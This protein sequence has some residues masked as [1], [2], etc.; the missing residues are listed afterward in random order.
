V[1]FA[2][3][4]LARHHDRSRFDCGAE[5]LD[6]YIHHQAS[7]DMRRRMARVFVAVPEAST[8]VAGFYTLGAASL[9]RATLPPEDA[10]RLPHYP[11]PVVL[12]G[13]LA[14]DRGWSGQ[15]LGSALL[16]D[17]FRRVIGASEA[18]A[19]Y[20]VVVDAGD[21]KAQAFYEHFGFA[22]LP[23]SERRLFYPLA[24]IE[25]LIQG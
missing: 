19:V 1:S 22:R 4:V 9:E 11:V 7:Q 13:R 18:L 12:I 17:A 5:P 23:D 24:A 8:E 10:K 15:G 25:R 2:I 14:V 3:E 21:E 6:R 20:A 16:A